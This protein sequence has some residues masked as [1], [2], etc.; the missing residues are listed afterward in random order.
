MKFLHK[1]DTYYFLT[2]ELTCFNKKKQV[3]IK[4]SIKLSIKFKIE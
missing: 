1:E 3:A 2:D 4:K